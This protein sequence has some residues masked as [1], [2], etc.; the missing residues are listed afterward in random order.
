MQLKEF[1]DFN[2]GFARDGAECVVNKVQCGQSDSALVGIFGEFRSDL[3]TEFCSEDAH[4]LP[5][6]LLS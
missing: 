2:D 3:F 1:G 5:A 4:G 6:G